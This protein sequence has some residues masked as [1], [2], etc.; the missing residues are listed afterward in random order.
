MGPG[1]NG[2][3]TLVA[4]TALAKAGWKVKASVIKRKTQN[5]ELVKAFKD[6]GGEVISLRRIKS[7]C[8]FR[9]SMKLPICC[10]MEFRVPASNCR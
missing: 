4:V 6:A 8:I 10:S 7:S 3:D 5:D 1:N 9:L 2:G